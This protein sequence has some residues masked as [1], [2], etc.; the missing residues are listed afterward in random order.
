M[1][2]ALRP[3]AGA[4]RADGTPPACATG[5]AARCRESR[6]ACCVGA[7]RRGGALR[8]PS[9]DQSRGG[10]PDARVSCCVRWRGGDVPVPRGTRGPGDMRPITSPPDGTMPDDGR[11]S[12][13][14]VPRGRCRIRAVHQAVGGGPGPAPEAQAGRDPD[15]CSGA[16]CAR[17]RL[18]RGRREARSATPTFRACTAGNDRGWPSSAR[19]VDG[20]AAASL[21]AG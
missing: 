14:G 17:P 13:D 9:P 12:S 8:L 11:L 21:P 10:A 6:G 15:G 16:P 2:L 4:R 5:R 7:R 3:G 1:G 18:S 19:D 20:P